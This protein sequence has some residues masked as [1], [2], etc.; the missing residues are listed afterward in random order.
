MNLYFFIWQPDSEI[1]RAPTVIYS[2]SWVWK[3]FGTLSVSSVWL[4]IG[5]KPI[6]RCALLRWK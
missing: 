1:S 6:S 4:Y 2:G 5:C 3:C